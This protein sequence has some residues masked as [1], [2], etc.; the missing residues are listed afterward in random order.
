MA[1]TQSAQTCKYAQICREKIKEERKEKNKRREMKRN[2]NILY[3]CSADEEVE[4]G[5][6]G[7]Q[8]G[9]SSA[10]DSAR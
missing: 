9:E 1:K 5:V 10:F 8:R 4:E 3:L 7:R 2:M 6:W